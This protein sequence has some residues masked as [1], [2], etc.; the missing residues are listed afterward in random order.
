M[1]YKKIN[2]PG[3]H[4]K[5]D[6]YIF[7]L[8][9]KNVSGPRVS[10]RRI[11]KLK[12]LTKRILNEEKDRIEAE[13]KQFARQRHRGK[14]L[15][16]VLDWEAALSRVDNTF[17]CHDESLYGESDGE[18]IW[19]SKEKMSDAYLLGTLLHEALHYSCLLNGK[20]ICEK[21]EHQVFRRLGDDC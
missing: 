2:I 20:F 18:K 15:T 21:D 16:V 17:V 10:Q 1:S 3:V 5:W 7:P 6:G 9:Q 14:Q 11:N 13:F 4:I 12:H 19:I 8:Y